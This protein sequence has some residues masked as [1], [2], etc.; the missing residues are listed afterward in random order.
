[1]ILAVSCRNEA[2]KPHPK[3]KD[4]ALGGRS[5]I[6]AGGIE[7]SPSKPDKTQPE[8]GGSV[9]DNSQSDPQGNNN[10]PVK[11]GAP[12]K[13]RPTH[14]PYTAPRN[15]GAGRSGGRLHAAYD[16]YSSVGQDVVAVTDG[17]VLDTYYF[18]SG[19]HAI[20]VLHEDLNGERRI[21]RYGEV[22]S[23]ILVS[24]GETV[25]KGQVIGK[26]GQMNCCRPMLH[27][28]VFLATASGPLTVRSN[29]PYQRRSDLT[30]GDS[31]V[32]YFYELNGWSFTY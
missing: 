8:K 29:P 30:D 19:T 9:P 18:Y 32:K 2:P 23:N 14:N 4:P 13:K 12:V 5:S 1:M 27:L 20:E 10:K 25:K 21:I 15:Y 6:D 24:I 7:I 3:A 28:E 31:F 16:L 22:S 17:K 26:I 11:A